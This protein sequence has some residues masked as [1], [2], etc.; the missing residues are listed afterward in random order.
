MHHKKNATRRGMFIKCRKQ[1]TYILI[2]WRPC[3]I[4]PD[5]APRWPSSGSVLHNSVSGKHLVRSQRMHLTKHVPVQRCIYIVHTVFDAASF[6]Q[7]H[8]CLLKLYEA[9]IGE[10]HV[11]NVTLIWTKQLQELRENTQKREIKPQVA[12]SFRDKRRTSLPNFSA[13]SAW[14]L[15]AKLK[16]NLY[17]LLSVFF[18]C[19]LP[20]ILLFFLFPYIFFLPFLDLIFLSS[21]ST[22]FFLYFHLFISLFH[23]FFLPVVPSFC[24]LMSKPCS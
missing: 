23:A 14:Y 9:E 18:L 24:L 15:R 7:T 20:S 21:D 6:L 10:N 22:F 8:I 2:G 12:Y 13:S 17:D 16:W 1:V 5:H 4:F 3:N 19:L 11:M